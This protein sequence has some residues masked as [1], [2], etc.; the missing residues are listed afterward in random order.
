[1]SSTPLRV[2]LVEDSEDD[3][4]LLLREL[5][6]GG[7]ETRHE[8]VDTPEAMEEALT[9]YDWDIIISDY[10]MP[11][12]DAPGALA[13]ARSMG[14]DAPFIVVSGKVGEEAAVEVMR[15]GAHDCVMKD[16]LVR[17]CLAV[18]R[19][20]EEVE[21]RRERERAEAD[22]RESRERFELAVRGADD[23]LWDWDL[24]TNTVYYSP[25][26]KSILGYEDHEIEHR[27]E[28]W[29]KRVHPNDRDRAM[30]AVRE[31]LDGLSP[32]YEL[33]HR[34][35]HRD[36]SYR[37]IRARGTSV[38]DE[39]GK[40]CRLAGAHWDVTERK[41]DEE[42]LRRRAAILEA[43]RFAAERFLGEADG[44]ERG[45]EEALERLGEAAEVSRVYIFENFVGGDGELFATQRY[46][47]VATGVSAQIDNPVLKALPYRAAGFGRW[48]ETLGRGDLVHGRVRDLPESEQPELRA[49]EILSIIIVPIFVEGNWWGF[50]GFDECM[51]E[52]EWS[53]AEIDA[54]G[55]AASTLGAALRRQVMEEELRE[56]EERYG[57]V[58]E[59]ATD[60][61][62]LL[63]AETKRLAEANAAFQK[64]FGYT[65]DEV[66][67]TTVY[68][69]VAHPRED[70]DATIRRT[71]KER[72]RF[73]G[74]RKYRRKDGSLVDVEVGVSVIFHGGRE[75]ICTICRDV[76]ERKRNEEKVRT[77]EAELRAL[78]EAMDDPIFVIDGE[79]RHLEV[80]PTNA[81]AFYRPP[82]EIVGRTLHEI[83][84][85]ERADEFLGHVRRALKTRKKTN[86]EYGLAMDGGRTWF[87]G[88]V[89]PMLDDSV[90]WV[91]RDITGRKR[92]EQ[93]LRESEERF[94]AAFD[95]AAIGMGMV[96]PEGR[97]LRVNRPLCEIVGYSE[98]ELL[99]LTFQDITHPDDL[100]KDLRWVERVL[101]GDIRA[102]QL[103]KRYI[104]K[105][106]RIVWILLSVAL[107]RDDRDN[108]LYFISQIQDITQSKRAE[109]A[110]KQSEALYRTVIEQATENIF[111]VDVETRRIVQSN[112]AF[113]KALGYPE[114]DL[115]DMTLYDIVAADRESVDENIRLVLTRRTSSV[116]ERKYRRKDGSLVSVEVSASIILLDGRETLCAVA[117]DVT[118]RARAQELL[119]ERVATLSRI[120]ASLALDPRMESTLD[121]M[122]RSVVLASTAVAC[123]VAL[124]EEGAG[125][126]RLEGSH[127]LPDGFRE[128]IEAVWRDSRARS[129]WR[130]GR[131]RSPT[132]EAVRSRRRVLAENMRSR[133]LS[134]PLYEP[135]HE[136]LKEASWDTV[137]IVPLVSRGRSLGAINFAYLP[138][139]EPGENE[140]VFLGAVADQAAIAVE[141][142]RLYEQARS[143]AALEERQRLARELH[144]SVSQA[145]YGI[146]LGTRTARTLLERNPERVGDPLDYVLSLAQ[147]GLDEMRALIFELRPESLEQE[148]VIAALQKRA[149]VLKTRHDLEVE[150]VLCEEPD[151][152]LEVKETVYR[153]AQ[154]ALHNTVKHS[155]A[156]SASIKM[157]CDPEHITLEVS[158]DG[159]GFDTEGEFPG[160]LGLRSMRERVSRLGGEM[161]ITSRPGEG[162]RV[163]ARIPL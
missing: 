31:H 16:N 87:E 75:L 107:V 102:Y 72:R 119:E 48:V 77:S 153:I 45:I 136:S 10:R 121:A 126:L 62:F 101:R 57:A 86:F 93:S 89:S 23:G 130:D 132:I 15:A 104:R 144:D 9:L 40:T 33:E 70:I 49:E 85:E 117:H 162:A 137:F 147:A 127:G 8:R 90:V 2:L 80:A 108:P 65:A 26:W 109:E 143:I 19:S 141:N 140:Q 59:Q 32:R 116:G 6:R 122:A 111:L 20:L 1:M 27:F 163:R 13:M 83:F 25:R 58:V 156:G 115:E 28:E 3:A 99:E 159:V 158:D 51:A 54:L 139:E 151:V 56:G 95:S 129:V 161:E 47:W 37:W 14:L 106:G 21:A 160:H 42:D 12:F 92:D 148:G 44:W 145:L 157:D 39:N 155:R 69:L 73:V 78:F 118:E 34:L 71:L 81:S 66:P 55:A 5:K 112:P 125:H 113:R 110:L 82:D 123:S 74:E 98:P 38:R 61:I 18:E 142:A 105:D 94:R 41:K 64:M 97:W 131:E 30:K 134:N 24:R 91:A 114:Q 84:P 138:G 43:V 79:G 68:D 35:L 50:V 7:C 22:L 120:A 53:M 154:E 146:V 46:E 128:G 11:R 96:S 150:T 152:S 76:T 63:D 4:L 29:E 67:E 100:E 149:A 52:R 103:E 17:L 88:T 133:M 60:A 124:F 36:G 135:V